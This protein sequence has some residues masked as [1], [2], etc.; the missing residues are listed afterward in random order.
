MCHGNRLL[1]V[2]LTYVTQGDECLTSHSQAYDIQSMRRP[3][4]N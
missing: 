2:Q 4:L 3:F 1:W